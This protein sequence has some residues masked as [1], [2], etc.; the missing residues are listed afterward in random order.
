MI[1][2]SA[3]LVETIKSQS[4]ISNNPAAPMPAA[5]AHGDHAPFLAQPAHRVENV[6][7]E[8]GVMW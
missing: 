5:D 7:A 8:K 1:A 4:S 2:P 3:F 6:V